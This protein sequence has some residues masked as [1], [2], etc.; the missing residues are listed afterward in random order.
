MNEKQLTSLMDYI[1]NRIEEEVTK[2]TEEIVDV[3]VEIIDEVRQEL[4]SENVD[5]YQPSSNRMQ[6]SN[7]SEFIKRQIREQIQSGFTEEDDEWPTLDTY[8]TQNIPNVSGK[9]INPNVS[10]PAH[11]FGDAGTSQTGPVEMHNSTILDAVNQLPPEMAN[12]F[13]K[14]YSKLIKKKN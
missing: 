5:V 14:D 2:R 7:D 9:K 12:I 11:M 6:Q 1:D 3:V 4:I 10:D 8:S 13:N